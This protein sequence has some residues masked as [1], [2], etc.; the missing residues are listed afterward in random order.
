M[1]RDRQRREEGASPIELVLY[2]PL[3]MLAIIATVQFA[4]IYLGNQAA[5]AAA[6]EASRV[7]RVTGDFPAAEQRGLSYA[8]DLGRGVLTNATVTI[9]PVGDT[10]VRATV[11]GNAPR[12][13]PMFP[14]PTV[15]EE[16][17]GPLEQF[18]EDVP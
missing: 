9:E 17:Q 14:A 10:L 11:S 8:R 12:L 2:M 15:T 7:A 5:S 4:L 3:L 1:P 16:V 18:R 6:R 13:V